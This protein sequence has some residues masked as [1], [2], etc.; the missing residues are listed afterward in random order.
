MSDGH[1]KVM[2]GGAEG[3]GLA[4]D[5]S[6]RDIT[7]SGISNI[8]HPRNE[9]VLSYAP[10]HAGA[11]RPQGGARRGRRAGDRDP[12]RGRRP[13]GPDRRSRTTWSRPIVIGGCWR[14]VHQADGDTIAAAVKAA[15]EAQRDW[16]HWRFEDRAAVFLKAAELLATAHRQLAQRR[17]HAGPEQDGLPGRDRQRLRADRLPALQRALRRADL[18]GA[19]GV[20]AGGAGTGSITGRS[21]GSS[22]PSRRST[23]RPSAATCRPRR[24]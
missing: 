2:P 19:A 20:V 8:P 4:Y 1:P 11:S 12:R 13:R 3:D 17:D 7:M 21:R 23:S 16:G 10:G 9:P 24:P 15:V 18:P 6:S 5:F 22:T 14:R